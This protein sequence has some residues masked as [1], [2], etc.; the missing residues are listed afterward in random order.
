MVELKDGAQGDLLSYFQ[1]PPMLWTVSVKSFLFV[2]E[3]PC[4]EWI[5]ITFS[6]SIHQLRD[7]RLFLL[8]VCYK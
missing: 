2:T 1:G 8:L 7:L 3:L 5:Y 6:L 4:I